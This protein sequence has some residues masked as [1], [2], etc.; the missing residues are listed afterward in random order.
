MFIDVPTSARM[1]NLF[2][3]WRNSVRILLE[4]LRPTTPMHCWLHCN[5]EIGDGTRQPRMEETECA[6]ERRKTIIS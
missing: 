1:C 5:E 4:I 2:R 6:Q 3:L